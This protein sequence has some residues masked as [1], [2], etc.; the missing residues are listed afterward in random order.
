MARSESDYVRGSPTKFY[1]WVEKC[2]AAIPQ[3]PEVWICGDCHV[4]NLGPVANAEGQFKVEI[5]DFDQTVIGNPAHDL[6]RLGLS[7]AAASV[8]SD[9]P[10]LTI[11][12]ILEAM[13]GKYEA[14]FSAASDKIGHLDE[15]KTIRKVN[16]RAATASWTTLA[17]ED[18]DG[19]T[20][21]LPIGKRF[22]PLLA[23]E[24][25]EIEQLF[26]KE[27]LRRLVTEGEGRNDDADVRVIDAA[28]WRK[29]CSSLG[30]LRYAVLLQIGRKSD[31]RRHC[32][33][34]LKEAVKSQAPHA[35]GGMPRDY[36]RRLTAGASHLSPYLG[37]R[38]QA[39]EI[40]G[41]PVFVR[42]LLPQDLKVELNALG[43][44]E[45][46]RVAGYLAAVVGEAHGRQMQRDERRGW[47]AELRRNRTKALNAPSWLWR[48]VVD[49]LLDHQSGYLEHCRAVSTVA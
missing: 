23:E 8:V 49:L 26:R 47:Y 39:V 9:L 13:I 17:K 46:A 37:S 29:G 35:A 5:R 18:M 16:R 10:G 41:K 19:Q 7:L 33:L 11:A 28:Y 36:A 42:E 14:A 2:S 45:A 25:H 30:H 31:R 43:R 1:E 20:F 27:E 15:P 34:D 21:K 48:S 6:I 44:K 22:W 38:M 4:G 12:E 24:R 3:G 40:R 32:L